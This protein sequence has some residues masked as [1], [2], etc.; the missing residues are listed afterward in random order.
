MAMSTEQKSSLLYKKHLG[1]GETR[2][3]RE[4]FEEAYKSSFIVRPDQL[5]TF[6]DYIP[7]GDELSGEEKTLGIIASLQNGEVYD[8]F[9][10][11]S[12]PHH[13]CVKRFINLK[14]T[15]ID[16][17]TDSAFLIADEDGNPIKNI[18][19][20]NYYEEYYNYELSFNDTVIPFGVGDWQVDI[21][22]GILT[23]YGEVPEGIDHANPPSLSFYQYVG[24]N[25]F[26]QD[27]YG[28]DGA[29]L[30]IE[31]V[32]IDQNQTVIKFVDNSNTTTDESRKSLFKYISDK[33]NEIE[34]GF[35]DIFGWDANNKNEGIALSFEKII[36]LTYSAT[37]DAVKGYDKSADSEIGTLLS[38]KTITDDYNN[39]DFDVIYVSQNTP[40]EKYT[41]NIRNNSIVDANENEKENV[42]GMID[43]V[44]KVFLD[45]EYKH[46]VILKRKSAVADSTITFNVKESDD[47]ISCLF[48]Y[49]DYESGQYQPWINKEYTHVNFGFP[50]VT[51]NG[52][53]PPTVQLGTS[54]LSTFSDVITPDYY[55]PRTFTV[56]VASE[57]G[58]T[59]I[60]S[61]DFVVKNTQD[62]YLDDIIKAIYNKY[63]DVENKKNGFAGT[64]FLR[65]GTYK[66][67]KDVD[68]ASLENVIIYGEGNS[69]I[70]TSDNKSIQFS[71]VDTTKNISINNVEIKGTSIIIDNA[72][73]N[74]FLA[75][76]ITNAEIRITSCKNKVYINN[77]SST[78]NL[79]FNN[80]GNMDN[81]LAIHV[82]SSYFKNIT[83]N[84]NAGRALIKGCSFNEFE[85]A[86]ANDNTN[87]YLKSN[88]I[89]KLK[90]KVNTIFIDGN[91][92]YEYSG[93][94][95]EHKEQLPIMDENHK[96][97]GSNE[98]CTTEFTTS[99][100]LPLFDE[101]DC[102]HTK[103][104]ELAA[105]LNY[106]KENNIIELIYDTEVLQVVDGTLTTCITTDRIVLPSDKRVFERGD[107]SEL[108]AWEVKS[109]DHT[110]DPVLTDVLIDLWKE[111]ADLDENGK[112]PLQQLPDS[113]AY[114][115]LLCVGTWSFDDNNGK[116]PTFEDASIKESGDEIVNK[117][118]KG[119]FF[120]VNPPKGFNDSNENDSDN[121]NPV[122]NQRAKDTEIYTAGDW[123]IYVGNGEDDEENK[124]KS[125]EKIDRAYSDPTYSILAAQALVPGE[126]HE[127]YWKN[128][129]INNGGML[130]LSNKTL[131]EA[132][133]EINKM[134][135]KLAP[136]KPSNINGKVINIKNEVPTIKYRKVSNEQRE[137]FESH[138]AYDVSN[139][140]I[141]LSSE[142]SEQTDIPLYKKF[143]YFGDKAEIG[144]TLT[145]NNPYTN[146]T[147]EYKHIHP[148]S[149]NDTDDF[150]WHSEDNCI[151]FNV[152]KPI[153]A[154]TDADH[155]EGFWKG[156]YVYVYDNNKI[157]GTHALTITLN[158][159][160]VDGLQ[161]NQ[162]YNYNG[163]TFIN[164]DVVS[165]YFN[166]N[167]SINYGTIAPSFA[168]T[169]VNENNSG[170]TLYRVNEEYGFDNLQFRLD[171][172]YKVGYVPV[173]RVM[174]IDV[175][176]G[177]K[178]LC[179]TFNA[180]NYISY[181][182]DDDYY[183][184]EVS[185]NRIHFN[186]EH[187]TVH[188]NEEIRFV[189]TVYDLY[190][191]P[192]EKEILK[193]SGYLFDN[194]GLDENRKLS[195]YLKNDS[196]FGFNESTDFGYDYNNNKMLGLIQLEETDKETNIVYP[197]YK[198]PDGKYEEQFTNKQTIDGKD[199]AVAC[200]K[201]GEIHEAA[202]FI[203]KINVPDFLKNDWTINTLNAST[204][205][206]I[207]QTC[208]VKE[209]IDDNDNKKTEKVTS[210]WD[211][212]KPNNGFHIPDPNTFKD[213]VMYAGNSDTFTK[214]I[215][216]GRNKT[217]SGDVY[218]R[219]GIKKDS[220]LKFTNIELVEEI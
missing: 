168:D 148:I 12:D 42:A 128:D 71:N 150:V 141:R 81:E 211:C 10:S 149:I 129:T 178:K 132:F 167:L 110:G 36:P 25:G 134:L 184:I 191:E 86:N 93:R 28:F 41:I 27:T 170:I 107:N 115:G 102:I 83:F 122:K 125:W 166:D 2:L 155:G 209:T 116:Y 105:P 79:T 210:W 78:Q 80:G 101:K 98:N 11:E 55:G 195:G 220:G 34:E 37:K 54:A 4:V 44:F 89:K 145:I 161:S 175:F 95:L 164:Y 51:V 75:N 217:Y 113:V 179:E 131:I 104:A 5:W 207:L 142:S 39:A 45:D 90:D 76:I 32:T 206:I 213:A 198:Y 162:D 205:D 72:I 14:L 127:W 192:H 135:L 21:Y 99:A 212:N 52:R 59:N 7:C 24:G 58:S 43:D 13:P 165:P 53:L 56:T 189:A 100:K 88:I 117:L 20:F 9:R 152:S 49:W 19:P 46:F 218:V 146:E 67:S 185:A 3:S 38:K 163:S 118:Q 62:Y 174:D 74:I 188:E 181:K 6:S 202:G 203:L 22:S 194:S 84:E 143:I 103:F 190:G 180:D 120:I 109:H 70:I 136:K 35:V 177:D 33:A 30:P 187:F 92:I 77:I 158:N 197:V 126:N 106:F 82:I 26:R 200:Y 172:V 159:V 111:K 121:D 130:D 63:Y 29:I 173:D 48:L 47:V 147:K 201:I 23:F 60:K 1:V 40:E 31:N 64:I 96:V 214:R 85:V 16:D 66:L 138:E 50:V 57:E 193:R 169:L 182:K 176:V 140:D 119:W 69:T 156:T 157:D 153:E 199:Y 151:T 123:L 160:A 208:I 15:K 219:I 17:G 73:A 196:D 97:L 183:D 87:I 112:V 68:L 61:A 91:T 186:N 137:T 144:F 216:F 124:N 171:K 94:A 18:I 114:G 139:T 8:F 154:M 215:T 204:N 108:E 65:S 133:Y